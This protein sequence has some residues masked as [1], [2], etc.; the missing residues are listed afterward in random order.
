MT[1][2]EVGAAARENTAALGY[3]HG[4]M[5]GLAAFL[6]RMV[7]VADPPGDSS[8]VIHVITNFRTELARRFAAPGNEARR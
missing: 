1:P 2:E 3:R 5:R 7:F 8:R 4:R 6:D